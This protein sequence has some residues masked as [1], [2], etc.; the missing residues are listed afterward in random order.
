MKAQFK[1]GSL[2][3][4]SPAPNEGHKTGEITAVVTREAGHNYI[5]DGHDSEVLEADV[6]ESYRKNKPRAEKKA[7]TGGKKKK[8]QAAAEASAVQ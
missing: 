8:K 4:F 7:S 3:K 5:V 2:V 6:L 1:L